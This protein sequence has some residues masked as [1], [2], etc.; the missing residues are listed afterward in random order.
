MSSWSNILEIEPVIEPVIDPLLSDLASISQCFSKSVTDFDLVAVLRYV[1]A[2]PL[3]PLAVSEVLL[4]LP[5][6]P[7]VQPAALLV[8]IGI[9]DFWAILTPR[10]PPPAANRPPNPTSQWLVPKQESDI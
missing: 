3:P 8:S 5:L 4:P 2:L 6:V 9:W 10:Q 1:R 7:V